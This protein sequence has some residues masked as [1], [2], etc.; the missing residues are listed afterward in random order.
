MILT[1]K[2]E[3]INHIIRLNEYSSYLEIGL[4]PGATSFDNDKN[5]SGGTWSAVSC[6]KKMCVDVSRFAPNLPYFVGTSDEFFKHNNC[7]YDLIYID[8]DHSAEQVSIDVNNS[9]SCL[10]PRGCII[11]HDVNPM[12]ENSTAATAHG[13]AYKT[14]MSIRQGKNLH[15]FCYKLADDGTGKGIA[16]DTV[17]IVLKGLNPNPYI[18][19][20]EDYSYNYFA[21]N[22]DEICSFKTLEEID[23]VFYDKNN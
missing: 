22:R 13:T 11:M 23:K 5:I 17:G 16:S 18:N 7:V 8:G 2:F 21:A 6:E 20:N 10:S 1:Y 9:L 4:G 15:S 12:T 3:L 19:I 14:F